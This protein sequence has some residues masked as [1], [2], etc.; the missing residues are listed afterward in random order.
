MTRDEIAVAAMR[1]L[2]AKAY[3]SD[4]CEGVTRGAD[5]HLAAR[6]YQIADA[7]QRASGTTAKKK[8]ATRKP[9]AR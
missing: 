3:N 9:P 7:M 2:I 5:D 1:A 8:R 4:D 6:A